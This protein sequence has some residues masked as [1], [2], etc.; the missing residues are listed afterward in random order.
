MNTCVLFRTLGLSRYS[1]QTTATICPEYGYATASN[2]VLS[3]PSDLERERKLACEVVNEINASIRDI[4]WSIELLGWENTLPGYG[5]PHDPCSRSSKGGTRQTTLTHLARWQN[6]CQPTHTFYIFPG[7]ITDLTACGWVYSPE[8]TGPPR[9]FIGV[10]REGAFLSRIAD[11]S[12][13]A[14]VVKIGRDIF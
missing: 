2:G 5:G 14:Q 8:T 11:P 12:S 4:N 9:V 6:C 13:V 7:K 1:P 3:S 10:K